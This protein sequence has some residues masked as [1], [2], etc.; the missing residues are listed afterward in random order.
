MKIDTVFPSNYLKASDLNGQSV[1]VVIA[2]VVMEQLDDNRRLVI[3][4]QNKKK[5]LLVNK[6]NA[7][8]IAMV[9]GDDTDDW[10]GHPVTIYPT[11]VDFKGKSVEALRVNAKPQPRTSK[12][13]PPPLAIL[14]PAHAALDDEIPF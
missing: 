14:E 12:A 10:L 11:M 5:G 7:N 4:F 8:N 3:Y 2:S 9:L 13:P 1:Q 6:T